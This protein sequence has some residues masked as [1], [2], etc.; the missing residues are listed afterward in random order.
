MPIILPVS[1]AVSGQT[2]V[3]FLQGKVRTTSDPHD[4]SIH[5]CSKLGAANKTRNGVVMFYLQLWGRHLRKAIKKCYIALASTHKITGLTEIKR[6]YITV[7][8]AVAHDCKGF[9]VE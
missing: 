1:A 3:P 4:P 6:V 8:M 2:I 7:T 9:W 5:V